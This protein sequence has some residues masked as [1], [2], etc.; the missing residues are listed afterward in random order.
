MAKGPRY[1]VKFRRRREGKTDY[2]KR[3]RLLLS[4]QPR[5]VVRKSLK[6]IRAQ[7][8]I[9]SEKGDITVASAFSKELLKYGYR[10]STSST[11]AAYLTGLLLGYRAKKAGFSNAILDIGLYSPTK[12]A[13]VFAT[14][15]GAID[16]G[17]SI[18]H[19]ESILP[20]EDRIRGKHINYSPEEFEEIKQR[21]AL[22]HEKA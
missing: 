15:K 20:S 22:S 19:N 18:P 12:G 5:L 1:K 2:R 3:L 6:H 10:A 14:L 7:L 9:P 16:A 4:K 13:R 21:I 17:L 8:V 11:P